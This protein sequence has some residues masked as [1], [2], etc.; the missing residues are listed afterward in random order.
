MITRRRFL[1]AV[2]IAGLGGCESPATRGPS[3]GLPPPT[4]SAAP[5]KAPAVG[6]EEIIARALDAA[7]RAGATYADA[8][9]HKRRHERLSTREDHVVGVSSTE[10]YGIGVRVIHGGAWGFSSSASVTAADAEDA[11]RR[12][13]A[14]AKADA[15]ARKREIV[16]APTPTYREKWTTKLEVDPFEVPLAEKAAMVL[17]IWP[18]AKQVAGVG[19]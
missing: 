2:A 11:A 7:K 15:G 18:E 16:L 6:L 5:P 17:A 19:Y 4:P 12:A 8:R 1:G 3:P 9:I 14:V 13:V 10:S